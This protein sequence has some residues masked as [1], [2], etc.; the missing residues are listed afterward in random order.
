M[1]LDPAGQFAPLALIGGLFTLL[2]WP[3]LFLL[4]DRAEESGRER[5]RIWSNDWTR[6]DENVAL[7]REGSAVE[8]NQ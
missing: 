6:R 5:L 2:T 4:S 3:L 1:S 8:P 7:P